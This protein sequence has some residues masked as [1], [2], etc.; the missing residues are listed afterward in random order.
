MRI[1]PVDI[2]QQQFTTKMFRGYDPDEVEAFLED[3]AEDYEAVIKEHALLKEQLAN[4]EERSRGMAERER[5][6]QETLTTTQRLTE[7][8][9]GAAKHEAQLVV[10]DAELQGEKLLEEAR[11]EEARLRSHI[12]AVK[13]LRR[14]LT[15]DLRST[16][17]RYQRVLTADLE[18]PDWGAEP[19]GPAKG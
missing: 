7:E 5:M 17:E 14:E 9:K 15:E 10:R 2:R 1:S 18:S 16:L 8:M 11:G 6:L 3:V 4:L 12:Q 19:D 13:R